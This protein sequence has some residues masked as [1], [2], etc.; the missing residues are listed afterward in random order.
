MYP[1]KS[2][3][4]DVLD[5]KK[6]TKFAP[7]NDDIWFWCMA[8]LNGF[9]IK[10]IEKHISCPKV[11]EG[12]Q[13]VALT[14][15]NDH[16]EKLFWKDFMNIME[17]YHGLEEKLIKEY[18]LMHRVEIAES[19]PKYLKDETYYKNLKPLEIEAELIVWFYANTKYYLNL[20]EPKTFN[21]KIQWMKIFDSTLLKTKLADK[22]L[23]REYVKEKIGEKYLVPLLGVWDDFDEI[24]F[25]KL[26]NSF[27]LK[28]NHG[29]GWNIIVKDKS[30]F[31]IDVA[32]EKFN[33][34]MNSN[35][36]FKFG[37]E[38]HYLNIKPKIIAEKYMEND[39]NDLY[40]YKV[41][42]F[43]GK[44]ESIMFLS[45]RKTGLKM[46]FFDL[47]WN[48][49]PFTYTFPY[50]PD[51][52]PRPKNLDLLISLSEKLSEGFAH[53]RVDFY[54]LNDGS[55][56]FGELTFSS[57]SGSCK[58]NPPEQNRIYGDLIKLPYKSLLP[59]NLEH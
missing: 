46:A 24:D 12:S 50:N 16:G 31:E 2:L 32:R 27:V 48:K 33:I 5:V 37:L 44:A 35:F 10:F 6:F 52:I 40:D 49:L 55:L 18:D 23:V 20:E 8:I 22:Y 36:A 29:C 58:W 28:A 13:D 47:N 3:Y 19:I 38:L 7:T 56:K 41:F 57:A 9:K 21:E 15:I 34:W 11:I 30:K 54:I 53:V 42:C 14:K 25:D 51:N 17:L 39:N 1:P 59:I 43:N 45:E 26:P 4:K